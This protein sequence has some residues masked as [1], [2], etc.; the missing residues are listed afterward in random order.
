MEFDIMRFRLYEV[1]FD[2][3]GLYHFRYSKTYSRTF[4]G[5]LMI[6]ICGLKISLIMSKSQYVKFL[7]YEPPT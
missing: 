2:L 7:F 5:V 4:W 3:T 1:N 6:N